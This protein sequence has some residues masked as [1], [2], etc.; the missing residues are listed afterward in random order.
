[1]LGW[2]LNLGFGGGEQPAGYDANSIYVPYEDSII[3]VYK[4]IY[5]VK[6]IYIDEDATAKKIRFDWS[7]WLDS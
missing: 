2:A 5:T 6:T 4:G 3:N 1:M 7:D